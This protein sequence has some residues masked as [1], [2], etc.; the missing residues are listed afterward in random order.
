MDISLTLDEHHVDRWEVAT[1]ERGA[2]LRD[3]ETGMKL[4]LRRASHAYLVLA[5]GSCATVGCQVPDA[6]LLKT[7][8]AK[9]TTRA[10]GAANNA[11]L[12]LTK[13]LPVVVRLDH[14]EAPAVTIRIDNA[15]L[16]DRI[17]A[18]SGGH[19]VSP[20]GTLE[21]DI[22]PGALDRDAEVSF[23][24][25]ST[26]SLPSSAGYI[27]GLRVR[28]DLGGARLSPGAQITFKSK[29]EPGT[30]ARLQAAVPAGVLDALGVGPAGMRAVLRGPAIGPLDTS[31]D[32]GAA[33]RVVEFGGLPLPGFVSA[34]AAQRRLLGTI[35]EIPAMAP[36]TEQEVEDLERQGI[37]ACDWA[38]LCVDHAIR[39]GTTIDAVKCGVTFT[40]GPV[41]VQVDAKPHPEPIKPG[42]ANTPPADGRPV[43]VRVRAVW[44]AD[45]PALNNQ[46]ATPVTVRFR[47]LRVP[48]VAGDEFQT[49]AKGEVQARVVP[50]AGKITA[51][52]YTALGPACGR[53]TELK[54]GAD[55]VAEIKVPRK[56]PRVMLALHSLGQTPQGK[57][58]V[59][60]TID[61]VPAVVDVPIDAHGADAALPLAVAVADD[62][63]HQLK[64]T[65]IDFAGV[66]SPDVLPPAM[67][68]QRNGIYHA[69]LETCGCTKELPR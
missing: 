18:A 14:G 10:A 20:D 1:R 30:L 24:R 19:Y 53:E 55:G 47:T 38:Q 48:G 12:A 49:D 52:G 45:D 7:V 67:T 25:L 37:L 17:S 40:G 54:P 43:F 66:A 63:P 35:R 6:A 22:P 56:D 16:P 4:H 27:P 62:S 60:Y 29:L 59:H 11:P 21:A 69:N 32:D 57:A 41:Q 64:I 51:I 3:W 28:M 33:W 2:V 23:E 42:G 5:V 26:A 50:L 13:P 65:A 31:T 9:A 36:T 44:D 61:G 46:P 68:I 34:P 39:T 8:A 58:R 15:G